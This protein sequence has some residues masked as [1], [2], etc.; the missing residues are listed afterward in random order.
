MLHRVA[1]VRSDVSEE[2]IT[3]ILHGN[4]GEKIKS[5][6]EYGNS[7]VTDLLKDI[8]SKFQAIETDFF[9]SRYSFCGTSVAA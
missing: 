6:Y 9:G 8:R 7:L 3:S 5:Y 4:R 2:I 1:I